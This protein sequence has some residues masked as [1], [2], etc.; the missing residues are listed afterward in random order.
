MNRWANKLRGVE[1]YDVKGHDLGTFIVSDALSEG[2]A[3]NAIQYDTIK[4]NLMQ[5]DLSKLSNFLFLLS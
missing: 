5:Y 1:L 4:Y 3:Y 2:D